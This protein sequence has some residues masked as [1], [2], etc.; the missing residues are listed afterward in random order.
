MSQEQIKLADTII[1][2]VVKAVFTLVG[3]MSIMIFS[4]L[5]D[6]VKTLKVDV[7]NMRDLKDDVKII[8]VDVSNARERLSRIEGQL[9]PKN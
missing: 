9:Q 1:S 8:K 5:K 6:D 7:G 2:W 4:D 3:G